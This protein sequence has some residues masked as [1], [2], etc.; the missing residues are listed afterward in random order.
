MKLKQDLHRWKY[1]DDGDHT[2]RIQWVMS[3][4]SRT[5]S[6]NEEGATNAINAI[7]PHHHLYHALTTPNHNN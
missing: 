5:E 7:K 3:W 2:R 1:R 6:R 4:Q